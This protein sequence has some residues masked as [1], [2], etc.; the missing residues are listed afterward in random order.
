MTNVWSGGLIFSRFN[1]SSAGLQFG[2]VTLSADNTTVTT[3]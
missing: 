2:M 3:D 1:A